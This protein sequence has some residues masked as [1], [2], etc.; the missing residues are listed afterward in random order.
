MTVQTECVCVGVSVVV[1]V[2]A[3][4]ALLCCCVIVVYLWRH[5]F[6]CCAL[7][8]WFGYPSGLGLMI[9]SFARGCVSAH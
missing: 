4:L 8:L 3:L 5:E 1:V 6:S 9:E 7:V 2:V